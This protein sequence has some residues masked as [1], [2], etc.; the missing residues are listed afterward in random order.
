VTLLYLFWEPSNP[1]AHPIFAQHRAELARFS[2]VMGGDAIAFL[3]ISYPEL[4]RSWDT[5]P[6]PDWLPAHVSR[7]RARYGVAASR[8]GSLA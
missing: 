4:W 6:Q 7:L 2:R 5:L 3:P 1:E 8:A